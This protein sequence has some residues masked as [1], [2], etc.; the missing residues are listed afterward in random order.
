MTIGKY[1][2]ASTWGEIVAAIP[3][4][5]LTNDETFTITYDALW[6]V[7]DKKIG[8][9]PF[10]HPHL[11]VVGRAELSYRLPDSADRRKGRKPLFDGQ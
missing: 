2:Q 10:R 4:S 3:H 9:T 7:C 11:A 1:P 5:G 6:L 8:S